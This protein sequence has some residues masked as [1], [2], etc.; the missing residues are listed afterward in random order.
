MLVKGQAAGDTSPFRVVNIMSRKTISEVEG[1]GKSFLF[2]QK[3][4]EI[5]KRSVITIFSFWPRVPHSQ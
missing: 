3:G 4:K 2:E 5:R 1:R